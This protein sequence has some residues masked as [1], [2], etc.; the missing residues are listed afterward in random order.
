ML[1][2][3][4]CKFFAFRVIV[5]FAKA[6]GSGRGGRT[7]SSRA[8]VYDRRSYGGRYGSGRDSGRGYRPDRL[9]SFRISVYLINPSVSLSLC[10]SI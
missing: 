5:E 2:L 3:I 6:P 7:G 1:E 4:S 8:S 10:L 9:A